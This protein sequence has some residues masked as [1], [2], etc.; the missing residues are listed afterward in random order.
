L[1]V[2]NFCSIVIGL[3]WYNCVL[4]LAG[5]FYAVLFPIF[6]CKIFFLFTDHSMNGRG[7]KANYKKATFALVV[8]DKKTIPMSFRGHIASSFKQTP[9]VMCNV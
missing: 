1:N 2:I 5:S 4:L 8:K 9:D 7:N 3:E 6:V